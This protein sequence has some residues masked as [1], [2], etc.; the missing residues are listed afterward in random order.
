MKTV[1]PDLCLHS[2]HTFSVQWYGGT[3][4][5]PVIHYLVVRSTYFHTILVIDDFDHFISYFIILSEDTIEVCNT[6]CNI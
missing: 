3:F 2:F 1:L 5:I 4:K 6:V